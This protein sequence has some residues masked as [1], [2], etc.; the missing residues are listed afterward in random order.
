MTSRLTGQLPR[1]D[2]AGSEREMQSGRSAPAGDADSALRPFPDPVSPMFADYLDGLE[3]GIL[4]I[5][6][7]SAC[8]ARQWP[9]RALCAGCHGGQFQ[10]AAIDDHGVVHTFTV[11]HRGFDPWFADRVPYGIVVTDLGNGIRILGNYLGDDLGALACG[12]PVRAR[13]ERSGGHAFV[14]WVPAAEGPAR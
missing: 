13:Y 9:P 11:V 6:E 12:L 8:G 3:R 5:S 4:V 7:C 10:S 2:T 14:G 1:Q